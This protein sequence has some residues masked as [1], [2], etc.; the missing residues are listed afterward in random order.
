MRLATVLLALLVALALVA[1]P[2]VADG[3]C[4]VCGMDTV[5]AAGVFAWKGNQ[6]T[7]FCSEDHRKT[8]SKTPETYIEAKMASE[9]DEEDEER[10]EEEEDVW[11]AVRHA[12]AVRGGDAAAVDGDEGMAC[13][14]CGMSVPVDG[15]PSVVFE[16]GQRVHTCMQ[17]HA[18]QVAASPLTYAKADQPSVPEVHGCAGGTVM[19]NGLAFHDITCTALLFRS[20]KLSSV[21]KTALA[22]FVVFALA[23]LVEWLTAVRAWIARTGTK[24]KKGSAAESLL[25][26]AQ[27]RLGSVASMPTTS[28]HAVLSFLYGFT[29]FLSYM[30]M[31]VAMTFNM[32]L[33]LSIII[34]FTV[35]FF[36]FRKPV[37]PPCSKPSVDEV[38]ESIQEE[39]ALHCCH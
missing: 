30:V 1:L 35:G 3:G 2:A 16:N 21:G 34:G 8:F 39:P 24:S 32:W 13:P 6:E 14:V 11:D 12:R 9:E 25:G 22:M 18:D 10:E 31:L 26:A 19:W 4:P 37:V 20:W 36:L 33:I 27:L 28:R 17:S 7:G 15:D 29:M 23:V 38:E 5:A